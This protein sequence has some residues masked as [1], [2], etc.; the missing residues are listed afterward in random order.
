MTRKEAETIWEAVRAELR[1]IL[2]A[3]KAASAAG[4][5][6]E[7]TSSSRPGQR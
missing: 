6:K 7:A 1:E 4:P 2:A 5:K 3:C